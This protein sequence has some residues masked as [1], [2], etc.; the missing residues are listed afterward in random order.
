M[1]STWRMVGE[2]N[3][4]NSNW[5]DTKKKGGNNGFEWI[6][7]HSFQNFKQK[8]ILICHDFIFYETE[9][10]SLHKVRKMLFLFLTSSFVVSF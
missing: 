7:K 10:H 4:Q 9:K 8:L 2:P 3:D 1:A 5:I 6:N